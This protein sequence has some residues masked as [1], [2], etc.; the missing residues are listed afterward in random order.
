MSKENTIFWIENGEI[1]QGKRVV[2]KDINIQLNQGEFVYLIGRTGSGK[3]SL[4]KALYGEL[5][6]AIGTGK[7]SEF[8]LT[9]LKRKDVPFLRRKLGIVFQD[10]QLLADRSVFKNLE[11]QFLMLTRRS[12]HY[13]I[14]LER[15][16]ILL[17][18]YF[19]IPI[20]VAR[21]I[22]GN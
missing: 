2:L 10:F 17:L 19:L 5:P 12:I 16:F 7:V 8:D 4:L 21:L 3:S 22:E 13:L 15:R 1:H 20:A 18:N 14:L 11:C 6:L 9:K